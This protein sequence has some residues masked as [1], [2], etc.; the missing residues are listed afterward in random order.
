MEK[1][2]K[3]KIKKTKKN[4]TK[5]KIRK[6]NLFG[7]GLRRSNQAIRIFWRKTK[8]FLN[9]KPLLKKT[10]YTLLL[11]LIFRI[12]ATITVPGVKSVNRDAFN[13]ASSFLGLMDLMGGGA[14]NRFSIVA[15]GISP[16]ITASILM[17]I[18]QSEIF[19]PLYRLA[20][21]GASGRRKINIITR[22]ITLI[23]GIF[24]AI[25]IS[26]S[27]ISNQILTLIPRLR[28]VWFQYIGL[29]LILLA[30]SM[31][32]L[33]LGE[34]I[35]KNGI[36]N[37]TSLIIFSGVAVALPG[38]L[39]ASF[40]YFIQP[41]TSSVFIGAVNFIG[42]LFLILTL[43]FLIS[44]IYK[45]ERHI[46]LQQTGKGMTNDAKQMSKLPM[47]LNTAGVI[48]IMFSALVVIIPLQ[49]SQL[50]PKWSY[51]REWILNNL[52]FTKPIGLSIYACVTFFFSIIM[53]LLIFQ[54]AKISENFFKSGIFIPGIRPGNDTEKYITRTLLR[55]S[56][57]SGIYLTLIGTSTYLMQIFI[58]N[59][60]QQGVQATFGG[61]SMIIL[62][63][64]A[65]ETWQ[66]M[67]TRSNTRKISKIKTKEQENG[68]L[69]W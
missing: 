27:F 21:S 6:N 1:D 16:Y 65:I 34:S 67:K 11:L 46:P 3:V 31:F 4:L 32:T 60:T 40:N 15:L 55:L 29:P 63:S 38:K 68:G 61:T 28:E 48:P 9:N 12:S 33:F 13:S 35:T 5:I 44:F 51:E 30:G 18:L 59:S 53:S 14:I 25:T 56:I 26:Q 17:T 23:I 49:V 36:G 57:F 39:R 20:N 47:K 2:K 22:W 45:S 69:L 7:K 42:Y 64:V 24:Q 62:I 8:L 41:G 19:P 50:L 52:T 37:G 66:Q 10:L 54:P 58:F 43:I